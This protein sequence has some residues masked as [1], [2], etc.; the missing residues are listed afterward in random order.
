[1]ELIDLA[2]ANKQEHVSRVQATIF[3]GADGLL[4]LQANSTIKVTWLND[5]PLHHID[6]AWQKHTSPPALLADGDVL[7]LGGQ[8][9]G[10]TRTYAEFKFY[11]HLGSAEAV[12]GRRRW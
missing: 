8:R 2:R 4:Y 7:R 10:A 12:L 6:T 5:T 3:V 9:Q 11:L 1:M